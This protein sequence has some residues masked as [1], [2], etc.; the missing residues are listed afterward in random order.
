VADRYCG[1]CGQELRP[2]A[3]FCPNCGQPTAAAQAPTPDPSVQPLP[4]QQPRQTSSW[5][6]GRV[7]F[8]VIIAPVLLAIAWFVFQFSVGFLNGLLGG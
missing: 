1:N 4:P 7:V 5:S 3:R 6:A 8:L 2:G